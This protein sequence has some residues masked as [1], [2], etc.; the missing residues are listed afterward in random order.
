MIFVAKWVF[1]KP[2]NISYVLDAYRFITIIE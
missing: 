1:N 2:I